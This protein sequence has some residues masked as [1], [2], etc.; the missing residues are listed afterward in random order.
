MDLAVETTGTKQGL[1]QNIGTV[2]GRENNYAAVRA[3][4]I[5]FGKELVEC[6][7]AFVVT[8][9]VWIF[10]TGTTYRINFVDKNDT[11]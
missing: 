10:A 5:H 6:V 3:K 1:V 9:H 7:F 2:S 11:G 4:S 8:S